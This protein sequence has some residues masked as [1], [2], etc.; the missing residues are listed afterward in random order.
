MP[1]TKEEATEALYR[2]KEELE[3]IT[4]KQGTIKVLA[5]AGNTVGYKPAFRVL[6]MG[7]SPDSAIR[8]K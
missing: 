3:T 8:W 2:A 5:E 1:I 4:D 6:V 7:K